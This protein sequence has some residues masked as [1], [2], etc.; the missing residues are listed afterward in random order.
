MKPSALPWQRGQGGYSVLQKCPLCERRHEGVAV[1]SQGF[2]VTS[3]PYGDL[4]ASLRHKA[5]NH[6][7]LPCDSA[8]IC[9]QSGF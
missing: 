4:Q 7:L 2:S 9:L 6:C 8:P 1:P 3:Q 5:N